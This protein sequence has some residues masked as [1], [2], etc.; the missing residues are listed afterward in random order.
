MLRNISRGNVI[1]PLLF[2][3]TAATSLTA[4]NLIAEDAP[5][6]TPLTQQK[7]IGWPFPY[8][9]DTLTNFIELRSDGGDRI[10]PNWRTEIDHESKSIDFVVCSLLVVG[11]WLSSFLA[12]KGLANSHS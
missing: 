9:L 11:A 3:M 6:P 10:V 1:V 4:L 12:F 8:R 5:N 2:G 7:Q